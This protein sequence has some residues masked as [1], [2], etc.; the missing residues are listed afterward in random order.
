[1]ISLFEQWKFEK[2]KYDNFNFE[3]FKTEF[4]IDLHLASLRH[5]DIRIRNNDIL[6][7]WATQKLEKLLDGEQDKIQL[8]RQPDHDLSW[9]TFK[10]PIPKGEYGAGEVKIWD[11]GKCNI[12]SQ[13]DNVIVV[14]FFGKH[15]S[16]IFNIVKIDKK[17]YLMSKNKSSR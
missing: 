3:N 2:I 10:G 15:I 5:F 9:L 1:M 13:K 17:N 16:G 14:Q 8:F 11:K 6:E 7:S 12:L 4:V